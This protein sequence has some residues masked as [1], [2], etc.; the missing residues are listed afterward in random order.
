MF[1]PEPEILLVIV[2][3]GYLRCI[4]C[5]VDGMIFLY[6]NG[7]SAN[8]FRKSG[9]T[10]IEDQNAAAAPYVSSLLAHS[11][12]TSKRHYRLTEKEK[13]AVRGTRE[14]EVCIKMLFYILKCARFVVI[15]YLL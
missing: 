9:S 15:I 11:E 12:Y 13:F 1:S 7:F 14:L 2:T 10:I 8:I 6:R 5:V 3:V 4:S